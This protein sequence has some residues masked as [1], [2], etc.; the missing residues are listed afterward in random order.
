MREL[1]RGWKVCPLGNLV[2]ISIG[3][4]PSRDV[5]RYWATEGIDG[6]PWVAISDLHHRVITNTKEQITTVGVLYSNVKP[7]TPGTVLMSFKLSLGRMAFAGTDLFTNEAIAAFISRGE[8]DEQ[9]LFYVLPEVV[10]TAATDVAIK[11]ATLNKKSLAALSIPH[12]A[13]RLQKAIAR[14]LAAIDTAIEKTEALIAKYQQVKAG[15]MHDLFT[16]GVLP[17][18][19][20]RPSRSEAPEVYQETAIGWIPKEWKVARLET[21]LR[22][23]G[24]YLQTGPFGSQLHAHEYQTEGIPVVMPQDIN[25]GKIGTESIARITEKRVLSLAKHQLKI[26]DIVI[27]RRGELSRAAAASEREQGWLCGTGC[28]LLRLGR[29]DLNHFFFSH[30]YRYDYIQRQI[31][32]TQVGTTMPSLNNSVMGRVFFPCPTPKEQNGI[33]NRLSEAEAEIDILKNHAK[34]LTLQKLG[35]MQDLLTGKVTVQ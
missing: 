1:A 28:F 16:R 2:D 26:G 6:H 27:A 21:I 19:Q 35:L 4:T 31:A 14:V 30:I 23:S 10:R 33:S 7:V 13:I 15:L 25:E 8:I 34:K 17:N 3:G 29:T 5:P 12:P 22:E 11:G 32:G 9:F 20:L 24:G 18:G